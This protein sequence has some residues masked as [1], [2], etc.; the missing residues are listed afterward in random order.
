MIMSFLKIYLPIY[1]LLYLF[2]AFVLPSYRTFKRTGI[3]PVTFGRSGNAHDYIG[4]VMKL[5]V[6][7]LFIAVLLFSLSEK[8]YPYLVPISYLQI[9]ALRYAGLI[10]IHISLLW[11]CIAQLQMGNSWRIGIDEENKTGLVTKGVF[12][13]SRNPIFLG[14]IISVAGVFL[15]IPNALTFFL[16]LTTYFIIQIQIRL[17]EDFLTKEHGSKYQ[18]YKHKT[19]RLL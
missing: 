11:I 10:I 1:L 19:K 13:V 17:E 18:E 6:G 15:I 3:N 14:M 2:I 9:D 4:F 12:S 8:A 16:M 5:L 7:L